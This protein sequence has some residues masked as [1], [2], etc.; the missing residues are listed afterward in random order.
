MPNARKIVSELIGA[1]CYR[2]SPLASARSLYAKWLFSRSRIQS[3]VEFLQTLG[4]DG[5]AALASFGRW[6]PIL[7]TAMEQIAAKKTGQG[8][9]SL[10]DGM[11]LFGLVRALQPEYIIETGIAAGISTSFLAAALLENGHGHLYSIELSVSPNDELS[12]PD[13]ARYSWQKH[14]VGWA[15]PR[16]I[17]RSLNGNHSMILS[18]VRTALPPLVQSLPHVDLFFHDDL[19]TPEHMLWEYDIIW[20]KICVGGV[21]LSDDA[22]YAWVEFC[23]R[24]G[25]N[26]CLR[27]I[28]RLCGA[29][30]PSGIFQEREI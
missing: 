16:E 22:N 7:Q 24:R 8:G 27:N 28:D 14:G 29:R 1:R 25:L 3:P 9:V 20:P 4:I 26:N 12:L 18:D 5:V 23:R 30:K 21:L 19:H 2:H 15:I 13:G 6:R 10:K 11:I 17:R